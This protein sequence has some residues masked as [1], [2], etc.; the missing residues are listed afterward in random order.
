MAV[1][2]ALKLVIKRKFVDLLGQDSEPQNFNFSTNE[3][4]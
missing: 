2:E 1:E 3:M 4:K